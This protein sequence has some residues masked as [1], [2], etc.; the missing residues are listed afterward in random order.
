M[1]LNVSSTQIKDCFLQRT[2]LNCWVPFSGHMVNLF[3]LFASRLSNKWTTHLEL[4]CYYPYTPS[5]TPF[6]TYCGQNI[7][8]KKFVS[9]HIAYQAYKLLR[10][11]ITFCLVD[12]NCTLE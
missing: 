12:V 9:C 4:K 1:T 7:L 10:T 5:A 11:A 2:N 3:K 8:T 6:K